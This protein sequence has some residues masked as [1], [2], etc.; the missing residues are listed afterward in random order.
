SFGL[1]SS[2]GRSRKK[3]SL[4]RWMPGGTSGRSSWAAASATSGRTRSYN[5]AGTK[6]YSCFV[7]GSMARIGGVPASSFRWSS[8]R[9]I[10]ILYHLD[11]CNPARKADIMALV[12]SRAPRGYCHDIFRATAAGFFE[13]GRH[14]AGAGRPRNS[15]L[16]G[17]RSFTKE[18]P[19][20]ESHHVC[21]H[22]HS[23]FRDGEAQGGEGGRV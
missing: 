6:T 5:S 15:R 9:I 7:F 16:D 20:Q 8:L 21:D 1:A 12:L 22:R 3:A 18:T 17:G 19:D 11:P 14:R 4:E 10:G 2:S 13:D 23:G